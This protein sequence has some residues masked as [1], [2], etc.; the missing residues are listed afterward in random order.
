MVSIP[1]SGERDRILRAESEDFRAFLSTRSPDLDAL[2]DTVME[3]QFNPRARESATSQLVRPSLL[4]PFQ[5]TRSRERDQAILS[6]GSVSGKG[7]SS[8]NL[9]ISYFSEHAEVRS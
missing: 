1:C 3:R 8:A 6:S 2:D 9:K 4:Q 5:S 7:V